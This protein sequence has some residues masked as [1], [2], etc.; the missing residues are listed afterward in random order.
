MFEGFFIDAQGEAS[1]NN[2][3]VASATVKKSVIKVM[4]FNARSIKNKKEIFWAEVEA[5]EPH[6]I[7]ITETWGNEK[8][9]KNEI[10]VNGQYE[11]YR[12]DREDRVG[13][14]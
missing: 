2:V 8:L 10:S 5:R 7:G 6:V 3:E 14:G 12:E 13:V 11:P 9:F 1:V 4:Y